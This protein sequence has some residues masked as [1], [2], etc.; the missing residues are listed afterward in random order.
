MVFQFFETFA[1][2]GF[3]YPVGSENRTGAQNLF[4]S[5]LSSLAYSHKSFNGLLISLKHHFRAKQSSP[6]PPPEYFRGPLCVTGLGHFLNP[7]SV[8]ENFRVELG[9]HPPRAPSLDRIT[10]HAIIV[11]AL[12]WL[13]L[14]PADCANPNNHRLDFVQGSRKP[15]FIRTDQ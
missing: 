14:D 3:V 15:E 10:A 13:I 5:G 6:D 9:S 1:S 7:L 4:G 12:E 2:C 11:N 8:R